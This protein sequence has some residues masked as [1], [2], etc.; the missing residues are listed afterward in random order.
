MTT[1]LLYSEQ[2]IHLYDAVQPIHLYDLYT[3][4]PHSTKNSILTINFAFVQL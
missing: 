3:Q 4:S 2:Q 1:K